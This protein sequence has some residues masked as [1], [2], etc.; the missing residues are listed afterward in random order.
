MSTTVRA[1]FSNWRLKLAALGLAIFLWALVQTEPRSEETFSSIPVYVMIADTAWTLADLPVPASVQLRLDGPAR[2]I[3][4]LAREGTSVR[5]PIPTVG[6][7][8]T[9]VTLR[10][11]W[12]EL[13]QRPGL[14]VESVVPTAVRISLEPAKVRLLPVGMRLQGSVRGGMALAAPVT[15]NPQLVRLRGGESRIMPLD[16]LP[17]YA[18]DLG[19]VTGTGVYAVG[20]DTTGLGGAIVTPSTVTIDV[21]VEELV[22]RELEGLIVQADAGP[23]E[24]DVAIDPPAVRLTLSGA[25]TPVTSVNQ[26][27]L[28]VWI[29]PEYLEEMEPGEQRRVPLVVD[30]VPELVTAELDTRYVTVRR[31]VDLSGDGA[32]TASRP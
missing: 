9:V 30:G 17:L 26:R 11:E 12:V 18:F 19:R 23:D 10:R 2:E 25:R 24:E 31:A 29:P 28:R 16:S 5:I 21:R 20:V 6:S 8:D 27:S 14:I 15:V 3:I 22:E 4:S 7:P 13:G 32:E 1:L